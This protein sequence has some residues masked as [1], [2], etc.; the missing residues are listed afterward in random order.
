ML[1]AM[2]CVVYGSLTPHRSP[3]LPTCLPC[4]SQDL[5]ELPPYMLAQVRMESG[6]LGDEPAQARAAIT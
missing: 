4:P 2:R 6:D 1:C 3:L 5:D